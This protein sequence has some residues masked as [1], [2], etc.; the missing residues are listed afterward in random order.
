MLYT[1]TGKN[2]IPYIF[3]EPWPLF[4]SRCHVHA[5]NIWHNYK[6]TLLSFHYIYKTLSTLYHKFMLSYKVSGICL[7]LF[8]NNF[9]LKMHLL[10]FPFNK[11][12][13]KSEFMLET[14]TIILK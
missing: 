13:M 4:L 11:P 3:T 6:T 5:A 8:N 7:A 2:H 14:Y 1:V 12:K 9:R 10:Q